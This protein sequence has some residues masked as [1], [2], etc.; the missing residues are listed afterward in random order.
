[1]DL[2]ELRNVRGQRM[3]TMIRILTATM[4]LLLAACG[5]AKPG[6]ARPDWVNGNSSQFPASAY[7]TGHGQG[8]TMRDAN[9]RARAELAKNFSVNVSEQS[10]DSSSYSQNTAGPAKN[11][12]D[13]SR[14]IH[15]RTDQL[16]TGVE[17]SETWQ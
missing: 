13:V 11:S 16:L 17:I 10:T 12:L 15:T 4:I 3:N 9:D 1:M 8:D 5:S 7:L 6:D 2:I 14:D